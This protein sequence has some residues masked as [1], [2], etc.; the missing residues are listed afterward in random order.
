[1]RVLIAAVLLSLAGQVPAVSVVEELTFSNDG[2]SLYA[3]V[4]LPAGGDALPGI[5][6]IQG[7]GASGVANGWARQFAETFA[8][9]GYAV[10][11]PDKRGVGRS[12]GDWRPAGFDELAADAVAALRA[13]ER[14]PRVRPGQVGFMGLSQG[15]HIAPIAGLAVDDV[16]F[17]IDVVGSLT[18]LEQQLYHELRN[19]Y[20]QHGLDEQ[21]IEYLQRLARASFA[22]LR[23]E[24]RWDD[25]LALRTEIADGP[26]ARGAESWPESPDDPYWRFWGAVFDNDPMLHWHE[27]VV[28]RNV[29]SLVALGAEDEHDNV[30]VRASVERA[31]ALRDDEDF[32]LRVYP[33]SGHALF[34]PG[35]RELRAD[36]I[37]DT[38]RFLRAALA[39]RD[40]SRAGNSQRMPRRNAA[41]AAE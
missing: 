25:Y 36:F 1:M 23:D 9:R 32:V 31:E 16:P 15:G 14:H 2:L 11:L 28:E 38:D 24:S 5:V 18:T 34:A 10:L 21:Q 6:L 39:R 33:G 7:A 27:L 19:T 20:L 8:R 4:H 35:T 17:V 13:L 37:A 41:G 29:P 12:E 26:L 30:P 3:Q 40:Y 22:Y